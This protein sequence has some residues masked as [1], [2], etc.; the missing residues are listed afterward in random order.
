[1]KRLLFVIPHFYRYDPSSALGAEREAREVRANAIAR[2]ITRLYE[3]FGQSAMVHPELRVPAATRHQ[4]DVMIVTTG[5]NH[6]MDEVGPVQLLVHHEQTDVPPLDLP[7][8]AHRLL[9]QAVGRYDAFGYLEDDI[10]IHDPFLFDKQE[11]FCSVAGHDSLLMPSRYEASG[12]AKVYPDA[13]IPAVH[14]EKLA[15]PPGPRAVTA[16][17]MGVDP[18]FERPS[19][20][21]A[22]C[23]YVDAAQ[24]E[25]LARHPLFGVPN[26][27]FIGPLETAAT[28][29]VTETFRVYKA[30]S[31]HTDFLEVEHQGSHYLSAWGIPPDSHV[32]EA[33]RRAAEARAHTAEADASAAQAAAASAQRENEELKTSTSWRMT[34]PLR[35]F[36]DVLARFRGADE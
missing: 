26:S 2:A 19:N 16:R 4:V 15:L 30:V 29:A 10:V 27:A 6:L 20:P 34:E 14:L 11:W 3:T 28:A 8:A 21:H 13:D 36:A 23:F 35:R 12:G 33:A 18:T 24:M 22:G 32:L 1:M 25:R 31:P 17:W 5:P 7:F 9:A